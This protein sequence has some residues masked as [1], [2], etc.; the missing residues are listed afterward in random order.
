VT[1]PQKAQE[2]TD[3][4]PQGA[5]QPVALTAAAEQG[6]KIFTDNCQVCHSVGADKLIG[7][8]LKDVTKRRPEA[9]LIPWIRNSQKVI[10]SG[11]KYAVDLYNAYGKIQMPPYAFSDDEIKSVLAY[12]EAAGK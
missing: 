3:P 8:G 11:D 12:I 7:P 9:W 6:K 1:T 4:E 5:V 10:D 2:A